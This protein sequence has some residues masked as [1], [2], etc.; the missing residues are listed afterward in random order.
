MV[1]EVRKRKIIVVEHDDELRFVLSEYLAAQRFEVEN[2]A[3]ADEA[4]KKIQGI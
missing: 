2:T 3:N 4:I 1:T